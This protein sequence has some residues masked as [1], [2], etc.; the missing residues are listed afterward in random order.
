MVQFPIICSTFSEYSYCW[1]SDRFLCS[2]RARFHSLCKIPDCLEVAP[3]PAVKFYCATSAKLSRT[4]RKASISLFNS[5]S[6]SAMMA[7]VEVISA[8]TEDHRGSSRQVLAEDR[9]GVVNECSVRKTTQKT[10]CATFCMHCV[11]CVP[12]F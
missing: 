6:L 3:S 5:R 8:R 1:Y 2:N 7:F 10:A 11:A 4:E 12:C 9:Q